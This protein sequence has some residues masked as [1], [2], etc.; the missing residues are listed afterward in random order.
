MTGLI[1]EEYKKRFVIDGY[2]KGAI[3][4]DLERF[5]WEE[6][7]LGKI[8]KEGISAFLKESSILE[9]GIGTGRHALTFGDAYTYVGA[10]IS[11]EMI[12]ICRVKAKN[13]GM[14]IGLVLSDAER[15]AFRNDVFDNLISSKTFKFFPSPLKFLW[16]AR[17]SLRKGGRCIV[18]LEVMDSLWFRLAKKLGL[19]VPK[20]ERHYFTNEVK[21]LFQKAGFSNIRVEP[22]ANVFLGV[23]LFLW[24]I[25]YRTPLSQT[26]RYAPSVL[27]EILMKL[28][29]KMRSKFLVLV[30]GERR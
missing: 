17:R 14:E 10:D 24:Y 1:S 4:Y 19:K 3:T 28:D 23:Y 13:M 6:G 8:E 26:F 22:L 29:E 25:T 20:H 9:C 7:C 15:L 5:P 27:T 11:R 12:K 16:E 2:R 21:T 18:T 30:V